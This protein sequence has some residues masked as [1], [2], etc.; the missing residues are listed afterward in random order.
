MTTKELYDFLDDD[1]DNAFLKFREY[2]DDV[3]ENSATPHQQT[4]YS[5][6]FNEWQED[7][8]DDKQFATKMK[9]LV[10]DI[11]SKFGHNGRVPKVEDWCYRKEAKRS[12][13]TLTIECFGT[14]DDFQKVYPGFEFDIRSR[15]QDIVINWPLH[16]FFAEKQLRMIRIN[17]KLEGDGLRIVVP[18]NILEKEFDISFENGTRAA[19][20]KM[21]KKTDEY[22][23]RFIQTN[24]EDRFVKFREKNFFYLLT[25]G[26]AGSGKTTILG[27]LLNSMKQFSDDGSVLE[28]ARDAVSVGVFPESTPPL[29]LESL[30]PSFI[31][32][33]ILL[34]RKRQQKLTMID[35]YGE[36][37]ENSLSHTNEKRGERFQYGHVYDAI[38]ASSTPILMLYIIDYKEIRKK[39]NFH[40]I[41]FSY[42]EEY[43]K[44][45]NFKV[46][47]LISQW[48]EMR[49]EGQ[50]YPTAKEFLKV[51][52]KD[53]Y[54]NLHLFEDVKKF[55]I[56][57]YVSND[58]TFNFDCED[59][60][61]LW[62]KIRDWIITYNKKHIGLR[63][64][65][66][67]S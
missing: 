2:M 39:N 6:I 13:K 30:T 36:G 55:Q 66:R 24:I 33:D 9:H 21:K 40:N 48:D 46:L 60:D 17:V 4:L 41:I 16:F 43:R 26:T 42:I 57:D 44:R 67:R 8:Y 58:H 38:F 61:Q 28:N 14:N 20:E 50:D 31:Y 27:A 47:L 18:R 32:K 64:L 54:N 7:R 52:A 22:R 29:G 37:H 35:I 59:S 3:V 53:L 25:V 15:L 11:F 10:Y 45:N 49:V 63:S 65:F 5:S 19:V 62:I 34:N 12:G 51:E 23:R 1:L 56:S